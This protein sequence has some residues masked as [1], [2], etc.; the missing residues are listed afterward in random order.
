MGALPEEDEEDEEEDDE[1]DERQG[2][3]GLTTSIGEGGRT[4][5]S[6]PVP[7]GG[8]G[9]RHAGGALDEGGGALTGAS[10]VAMEPAVGRSAGATGME[11]RL[12]EI[13]AG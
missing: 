10:G 9:G 7:L 4:R 1:G 8:S 5:I 12:G 6:S 3:V 2:E 11:E 13:S